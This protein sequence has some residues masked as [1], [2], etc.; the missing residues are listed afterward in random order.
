MTDVSFVNAYA[1]KAKQKIRKQYISSTDIHCCNVYRVT[2]CSVAEYE[3][4]QGSSGD[5]YSVEGTP[6][7][8]S[9]STGVDWSLVAAIS[10]AAEVLWLYG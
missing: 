2:R 10:T 8:A 5:R 9:G 6:N 3:S 7:G 1:D 4:G